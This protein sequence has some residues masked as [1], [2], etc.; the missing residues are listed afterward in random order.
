VSP[1]IRLSRSALLFLLVFLAP[2]LAQNP[3]GKFQCR[4]FPGF[5]GTYSQPVAYIWVYPNGTYEVLDFT[6]KKGKT[7][8]NYVFDRK[9]QLI[10]WSSGDLSKLVGHYLPDVSGA[11][12]I[13]L[14]TRK[15][16]DGHVDGALPCIRIADR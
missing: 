6:I 8:G 3:I 5:D 12:V 2:C 7:S 4:Q 11:A 13:I 15:D 16:S 1:I 9:N 10:D 14:N